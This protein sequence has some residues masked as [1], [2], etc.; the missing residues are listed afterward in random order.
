MLLVQA[1]LLPVAAACLAST[2]LCAV[3]PPH[4]TLSYQLRGSAR[5]AGISGAKQEKQDL[6]WQ[7]SLH[8]VY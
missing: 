7:S 2:R 3:L 8:M 1:V 5:R 6:R 4:W